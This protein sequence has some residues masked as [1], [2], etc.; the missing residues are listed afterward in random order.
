[1]LTTVVVL[2]TLFVVAAPAAGVGGAHLTVDSP[3]PGSV[4]S[5]A[6]AEPTANITVLFTDPRQDL[7]VEFGASGS[8]D[9][10]GDIVEYQWDFD[11]DGTV[12]S[13]QTVP[14]H[15]Y[16]EAGTYN[17][18]LTVEDDDNDVDSVTKTVTVRER[19]EPDEPVEADL[20]AIPP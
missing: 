2:T 1:M 15:F 6:N 7:T 3:A 11:G 4:A 20:R 14:I 18:T 10:D 17:V 9:P 8:S 5:Q 12:D 19:E 13:R 16:S